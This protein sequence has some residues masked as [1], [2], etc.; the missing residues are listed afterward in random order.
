MENNTETM[1]S[2]KQ[3]QVERRLKITSDTINKVLDRVN[4]LD[5]KLQGVLSPSMPE[6]VEE[7]KDTVELVPMAQ[8][9]KIIGE[10]AEEALRTVESIM[11][12]LEL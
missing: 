2:K 3:P 12:R 6:P 4:Q 5:D 11:D 9:I 10:V 8:E 1:V 7:K